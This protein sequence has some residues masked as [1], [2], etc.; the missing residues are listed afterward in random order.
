MPRTIVTVRC[1]LFYILKVVLIIHSE[2]FEHLNNTFA[3]EHTYTACDLFTK[4]LP[5]HCW[6]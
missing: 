2:N 6:Q 5:V 4:T 3:N 1:I